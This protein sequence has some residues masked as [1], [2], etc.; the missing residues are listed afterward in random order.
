MVLKQLSEQVKWLPVTIAFSVKK[1]KEGGQIQ[2]NHPTVARNMFLKKYIP[3]K[4]PKEG[5]QL[6]S[7]Q[8]KVERN[9]FFKIVRRNT[10]PSQTKEFGQIQFNHSRVVRNMFLYG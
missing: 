5:G 8:T 4:R 7:N 9:M 1:R 2:L 10:F 3:C 6:Q